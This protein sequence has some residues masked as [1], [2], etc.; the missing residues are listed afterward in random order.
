MGVLVLSGFDATGTAF[1]S[2]DVDF[3]GGWWHV[4]DFRGGN[5]GTGVLMMVGKGLK[6]SLLAFISEQDVNR[7]IANEEKQAYCDES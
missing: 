7:R 4:G 5:E 3:S 6:L 2:Y 1:E